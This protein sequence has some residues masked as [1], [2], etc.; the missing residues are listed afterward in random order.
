M[1]EHLLYFPYSFFFCSYVAQAQPCCRFIARSVQVA[2]LPVALCSFTSDDWR[3]HLWNTAACVKIQDFFFFFLHAGQHKQCITLAA[4]FPTW[5]KCLTCWLQSQAYTFHVQE[6]CVQVCI[7]WLDLNPAYCSASSRFWG[8]TWRWPRHN[9][10]LT[11]TDRRWQH[12]YLVRW[13]IVFRSSVSIPTNCVHWN[14][15]LLFCIFS[16]AVPIEALFPRVQYFFQNFGCLRWKV[17]C[18][19]QRK[20]ACQC[21][22]RKYEL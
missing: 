20:P 18:R 21:N 13:A 9:M 6:E 2:H 15:L 14:K 3:M 19:P 12:E 17:P 1:V 10:T 5:C 22:W 16:S 11:H 7:G 4:I 8:E